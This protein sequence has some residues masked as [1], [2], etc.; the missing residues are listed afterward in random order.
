MTKAQSRRLAS[1]CWRARIVGR[2][3]KVEAW[4]AGVHERT[5][6]NHAQL[7]PE[8]LD[9]L[10]QSPKLWEREAARAYTKGNT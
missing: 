5:L 3:L 1:R 7:W 6:R 8:I 9:D 2:P 10:A 4:R